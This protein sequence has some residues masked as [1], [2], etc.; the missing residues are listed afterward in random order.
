VRPA[1]LTKKHTYELSPTIKTFGTAL[2]VSFANQPFKVRP[3][4]KSQQLA[5]DTVKLSHDGKP[6]V[7]GFGFSLPP[8]SP[9]VGFPFNF[10]KTCFG[11]V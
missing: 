1:K 10:S 11:Q 7:S 5:E 8:L 6:S 4:K 3:G 9:K 2:S